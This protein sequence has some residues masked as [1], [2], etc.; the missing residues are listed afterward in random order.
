MGDTQRGASA[1]EYAL[2]VAGLAALAAFVI[3]AVGTFASGAY[4]DQCDSYQLSNAINAA[5]PPSNTC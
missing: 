1:V 5:Y 3:A 2:L 4:K